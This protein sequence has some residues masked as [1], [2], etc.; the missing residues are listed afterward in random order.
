VIESANST[1]VARTIAIP[2]NGPH[3]LDFHPETNRLFCACDEGKLFAL[4]AS[5]GEI[6]LEAVLSGAPDVI[7]FNAKLKHLYVAVGDPGVIDVFDT[8]SLKK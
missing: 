5:S 3:G 2:A 6:L 1:S 4:D 8:R 7:F